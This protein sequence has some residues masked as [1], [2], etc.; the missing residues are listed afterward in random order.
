LARSFA[1][2]HEGRRPHAHGFTLIEIMIVCAVLAIVLTFSIPRFNSARQAEPLNRALKELTEA[3]S[4]ARARAILGGRPTQVVFRPEEGS[5]SV[6]GGGGGGAKPGGSQ[7]SGLSGSF[8]P[9]LSVEMLDINLREF[10]QA[11]MAVVTFYPNGICDEL[12]VVLR[13]AD[14]EWRK[15][16]LEGTTGLSSIGN[17]NDP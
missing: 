11:P 13:S 3:C 17:V 15:F 5:F 9:S 2:G 6:A 4:H 14:N 8:D 12:T 16:S 7:G 10:R 1:N